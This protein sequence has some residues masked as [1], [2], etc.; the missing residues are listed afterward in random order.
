MVLVRTVSMP[1]L[2]R[3][4]LWIGLFLIT[5]MSATVSAQEVE[6]LRRFG[7]EGYYDDAFGVA[8]DATGVYVTGRTKAPLPGSTATTL[9]AFVRK[10]TFNGN[11]VWSRQFKVGTWDEPFAIAVDARGV[12]VAGRTEG[13]PSSGAFVSRLDLAGNV[14]WSRVIDY[15]KFS[16]AWAIAVHSTGIYVA[17]DLYG[18]EQDAVLARLDFDGNELWTTPRGIGVTDDDRFTGV[19]V[20][21]T[22]VYGVGVIGPADILKFD[23]NGQVV[24]RFGD[25]AF[26]GY[27]VAKDSSG[28]YAVGAGRDVYDDHRM[29]KYDLSGQLQWDRALELGS[30]TIALDAGGI[31]LVFPNSYGEQPQVAKYTLNGDF[32]WQAGFGTRL[33]AYAAAVRGGDVYLAGAAFAGAEDNTDSFVARFSTSRPPQLLSLGP[34][35]GSP[36]IATLLHDASIPSVNVKVQDAVSGASISRVQ[37]WPKYF[38]RDLAVLPDRNGNGAPEL[39]LLGIHVTTGNVV[40]QIRDS[41]SGTLLNSVSFNKV[42]MPRRLV[43]VPGVGA[44]PQPALAVLG[45]SNVDRTLRVAIK[46]SVTRAILGSVDFSRWHVAEP[47]A[48]LTIVP[49]VNGNGAPELAVMLIASPLNGSRAT[50]KDTL[51]GETISVSFFLTEYCPRDFT[52][53]PDLDR[54]GRVELATLLQECWNGTGRVRVDVRDVATDSYPDGG[55]GFGKPTRP[56]SLIVLPDFNRNGAPELGVLAIGVSPDKD[57]LIVKDSATDSWTHNVVFRHEGYRHRGVALLPDV[58]GNGSADV[59]QLQEHRSDRT[60]RV[61]IKDAQTGAFVRVL[62]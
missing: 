52:V 10:Y 33:G 36:A 7:A 37:F 51:S 60:L 25:G 30:D 44:R 5:L 8:V 38:P 19:A 41:R 43:V 35:G 20:D 27:G 29:R 49:D 54:N 2:C 45:A 47:L 18:V 57:A 12:Y 11:V 61:M 14:M 21:D 28:L 34:L 4:S 40:V 56:I 26:N 55:I 9:D 48:D 31:Y 46:D 23:F 22:G 59:A 16:Q 6:W 24:A 58:N 3:P 32:I 62:R 13:P 42:Y 1:R 15:R 39:A 50:V 53:V 17:G